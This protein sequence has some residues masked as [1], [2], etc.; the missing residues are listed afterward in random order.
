MPA[1][2]SWVGILGEFLVGFYLLM[3]GA[4]W[5]VGASSLVAR[6]KG[7]SPLVVG[8]T[9]V[10]F[11]TSAP[12]TVVSGLA[13][14]EGKV[15]LSLGNVLGSNVANIGLVLGACAIV[16]PRVM[17][18]RLQPRE[19]F[20]FFA[21]VALLWWIAGDR[22]ISRVEAGVLFGTFVI[23]N[24]EVLLRGRVEVDLEERPGDYRYPWLF[25]GL[26]VASIA[27]GAKFV[28][29]G[30]EN[31]ALRLGIP[32]SVLGLTVVALGTSLPELA[33]GLGGAFKGES[34]ISLGNVVGSNIFN[35]LA[36][37][38]LV[39][40]IMPFDAEHGGR[41]NP[42]ALDRAFEQAL[43]EDFPIVL[44]FSLAAV[45]LPVIGGERGGRAKGALLLAGYVGYTVWL[46]VSRG[47]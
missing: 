36:V 15:D 25:I 40:L 32:Q 20:W 12:E 10:A 46:Y 3:K 13:A 2:D 14:V 24:V 47:V 9:I 42:A 23:Y 28:V 35:L 7:I 4:D 27:I 43:S 34:D 17:E 6:K 30:A 18:A 33:A 22:V 37:I 29:M 19:M 45:L 8:L 11:G 31:G 44:A 21:A 41:S 39:G 16:L 1:S 38:G 5:L 26:G